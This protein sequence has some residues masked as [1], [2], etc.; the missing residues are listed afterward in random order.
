[1]LPFLRIT[2]NAELIWTSVQ[3][4]DTQAAVSK[5]TADKMLP[6]EIVPK[7]IGVLF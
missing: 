2:E 5:P 3:G 7:Y 4:R 1:M 6:T